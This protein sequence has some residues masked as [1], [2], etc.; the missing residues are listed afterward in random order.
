M[1]LS[2]YTQI[3]VE[4]YSGRKPGK[5]SLIHARPVAG[6]IYP[7]SMDVE[8]SRP[9][10]KNH[11]VGTKFRIYVKETDREGGKPFLYTYYRWSYE[12]VEES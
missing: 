12:V 7:P 1:D 9:M 10:R 4:T 6:Q 2:E 11:P 3:V 8:C 5:S